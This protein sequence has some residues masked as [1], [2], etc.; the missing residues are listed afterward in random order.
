MADGS[1]G[2]NNGTLEN[3]RDPGQS[4]FLTLPFSFG[5]KS[6]IPLLAGDHEP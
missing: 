4:S 3:S 2:E 6:E 1:T 5:A